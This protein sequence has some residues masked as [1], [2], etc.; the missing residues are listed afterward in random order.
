MDDSPPGVV[1]YG[2]NDK[3]ASLR[4]RGYLLRLKEHWQLL[5]LVFIL[6]ALHLIIVDYS[7]SYIY[8]EGHYV[9]QAISIVHER[10]PQVLQADPTFLDHPSLAKLFIAAGILVFGDNPWGWRIPSVVFGIASLVLFYFICRKVAGKRTAAVGSFLLAF[11][12]FFFAWSGVAML[13]VF[14]VTFMLGS[15]LFFLDKRY[16]LSGTTL[17]LAG[18]CKLTGLFGILVIFGYW[19]LDGKRGD[20]RKIGLLLLSSA[21]VLILLMPLSDF[22]ATNQW[23]NP[24]NRIY[25]MLVHAKSLKYSQYSP[26]NR[27]IT[28]MAYPWEWILRPGEMWTGGDRA[29]SF[30]F[31]PM[32]FVLIVPSMFYMVY[33]LFRR[34]RKMAVFCLL[35]FGATYVVWIP[36]ALVTDRATY[37]YYFLPAVGAVCM[38]VGFGIQRIWQMSTRE[39][40]RHMRWLLRGVVISYLILYVLSFLLFSTFG[41]A[42]AGR[43]SNST[44]T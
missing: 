21:M 40:D 7:K 4:P 17:A 28:G 41:R 42:L 44:L 3:Q 15:F 29:V 39:K 25:D 20:I 9:P 8:D 27:A 16:V 2:P 30:G 43:V 18:L 26:E 5:C 12:N 38:A 31:T 6:L 1:D 37:Y 10:G 14:S 24:V 19:A 32:L 36:I 33:E 22:A 13:D 35:W 11:E 34:A 23:F